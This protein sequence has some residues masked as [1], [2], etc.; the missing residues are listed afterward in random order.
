MVDKVLLQ[1][2]KNAILSKFVP[3]YFTDFQSL[4]LKY[5]FLAKKGA[6]FVTLTLNHNLLGC[7]GSIIA[8][9]NLLDDLNSNAISAAFKDP[10]FEPLEFYELQN[11]HLEVSLLSEPEIIDYKDFDDLSRKVRVGKDGLILKHGNFQGTFL[12]QV[13]VQLPKAN[14]FLEHLSLKAGGNPLIYQYHPT[15]YRYEVEAIGEKFDA[16]LPL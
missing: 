16:I 14:D 7:I 2:A 9:R 11:L 10:R 5:P 8:H 3:N 4:I 12:P 15:I 6:C 13:W 1:I